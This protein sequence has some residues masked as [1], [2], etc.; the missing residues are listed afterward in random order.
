M[1]FCINKVISDITTAFIFTPPDYSE[2]IQEIRMHT[3]CVMKRFNQSGVHCGGQLV[4]ALCCKETHVICEYWGNKI[5][6]IMLEDWENLFDRWVEDVFEEDWGNVD[7]H[8][9]ASLYVPYHPEIYTYLVFRGEQLEE[10]MTRIPEYFTY[11]STH[12]YWSEM[13]FGVATDQL[14]NV[15][16]DDTYPEILK[17]YRDRQQ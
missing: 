6:T 3:F 15:L 1:T 8:F 12:H 5:G 7:E 4:K 9:T 11:L 13:N 17:E 16:S 14:G 2:L 10:P